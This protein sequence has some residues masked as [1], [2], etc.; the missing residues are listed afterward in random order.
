M[1]V[2]FVCVLW[3]REVKFLDVVVLFG[4]WKVFGNYVL[5]G[6]LMESLF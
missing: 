4:R 5:F 3:E 2:V 6:G 1:I